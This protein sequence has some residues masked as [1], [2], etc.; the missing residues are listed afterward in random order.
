MLVWCLFE[1]ILQSNV[2]PCNKGKRWYMALISDGCVA[3]VEAV[4]EQV[5]VEL[6][7]EE[8]E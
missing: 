6:V 1:I 8:L 4:V 3:K 2:V 5:E 7:V